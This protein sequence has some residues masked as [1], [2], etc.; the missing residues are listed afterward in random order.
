MKTPSTRDLARSVTLLQMALLAVCAAMVPP[1]NAA[2]DAVR[3]Y[4]RVSPRHSRYFEL[5]DGNPYMPI[6]LNL[7]GA[8]A[9][10]LPGLERWFAK[11]SAE[12]GNFAR[13]WLSNPFFDVEHVRS[14]EFDEER[15]E[16]IDA[17]LALAR[18]Y[19]IRLKLCTEHFRHL[20]EG[21]QA[22]AAK[23]MHL[24]ANGGPAL[25]T[26]DFFRGEA[27]R[28]AYKRK[29][30]WYAHRYGDDPSVF[31]WE[32]WNEM[33]AVRVDVWEPW[34]AEMLPELHRLFPKN[35]AMQ[36]LGSY[37]HENKRE[38][39][40]R[41]C[42]LPGNDVLQV[43]RYLDLGA[44][45]EVCHGPVAVLAAEAVRDLRAF[46]VEKPVLL[47]E[48]GAVEPSHTGPFKLYAEDRDGII[49]H[50]VLF[51]PFF[52]GAAGP[53]HIWHWD[54]YVD[55]NDL[56]WQFGRFNRAVRNV[57]PITEGFQPFE[58]P[59]PRLLVL[60]LKGRR[61]TL[62]WC[63]DRENTWRSELAEKRPPQTIRDAELDLAPVGVPG[64][65]GVVRFYDPWTDRESEPAPCGAALALPEFRRSL[66]VRIEGGGG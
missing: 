40:R 39:Y 23:P 37:D 30:A 62:L 18:K 34:S 8:P 10:G 9:D 27:G 50:D 56:W 16:R 19:G 54:V 32:L 55:R 59:H 7:C 13:I 4:V 45:W 57:D 11:L 48:S 51:A 28:A 2:G 33:D 36:S 58:L 42:L 17:L 65:P 44:A 29:L 12:G 15:A 43:H 52:A 38:R 14:G 35:L 20:G 46:G 61:L 5:T 3:E 25:D 64:G 60:G 24:K 47:A 1:A 26:A 31:G 53:G 22:W 63:R 41:L 66:V 49:L 21:S 6:G